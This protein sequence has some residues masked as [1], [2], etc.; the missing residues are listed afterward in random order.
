[1]SVS[2]Y[3]PPKRTLML[4]GNGARPS[5]QQR[6]LQQRQR[7]SDLIPPILSSA[8]F[9]TFGLYRLHGYRDRAWTKLDWLP[10]KVCFSLRSTWCVVI[11]H[12]VH[13]RY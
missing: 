2:T 3:F 8:L 5:R 4:S 13:A 9:R 7:S 11:L 10:S 1:M 12:L 6:L